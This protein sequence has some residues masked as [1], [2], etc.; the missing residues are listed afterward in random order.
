MQMVDIV[1]AKISDA[2]VIASSSTRS[3]IIAT[4]S[5]GGGA[6]DGSSLKGKVVGNFARKRKA[7]VGQKMKS[8]QQCSATDDSP[9][10]EKWLAS[11]IKKN[12]SKMEL[13]DLQKQKLR[14]EIMKLKLEASPVSAMLSEM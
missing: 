1:A 8:L 6:V 9:L 11:E 3:S 4:E 10:M 14:L 12:E 2:N 7:G 5:V 13:I